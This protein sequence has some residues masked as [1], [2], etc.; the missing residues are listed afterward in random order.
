MNGIDG[1]MDDC[2]DQ[3]SLKTLSLDCE[4]CVLI[5]PFKKGGVGGFAAPT[6]TTDL[7]K[8]PPPPFSKGGEIKALR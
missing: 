7:L 5:P 2:A 4:H 3:A 6:V 1:D 8:S